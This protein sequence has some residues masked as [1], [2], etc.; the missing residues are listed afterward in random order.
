MEAS[1]MYE[2]CATADR[3]CGSISHALRAVSHGHQQRKRHVHLRPSLHSQHETTRQ[4][5]P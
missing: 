4:C 2:A 1:A 3:P 5:L